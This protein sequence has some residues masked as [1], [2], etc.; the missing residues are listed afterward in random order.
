MAKIIAERMTAQVEGE[1][2]VF[3]IGMRINRSGRCISGCRSFAPCLACSVSSEPV[4][5]PAFWAS[6]IGWA[7]R[8]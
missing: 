5:T 4:R 7:I 1:V 3:L 2:I 8:R 6:S